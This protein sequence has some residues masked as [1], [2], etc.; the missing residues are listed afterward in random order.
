MSSWSSPDKHRSRQ[1]HP[2]RPRRADDAPRAQC[3]RPRHRIACPNASPPESLRRARLKLNAFY[4]GNQVV[5]ELS[6]DGA[7]IDRERVVDE[8]RRRTTSSPR[9]KQR[10][11][12]KQEALQPDLPRPA[13]APPSAVTEISGRGMG[14]DIVDSV[15]RRLKGSIGIQT[16]RGRG[17]TFQLRVPLTLAIMQAL[18]FRVGG[19]V[20]CRA[21][22]HRWS[23][24]RAP[25]AQQIHTVDHHEVLQLRDQIVTLVRLDRLEGK[26]RPSPHS[27]NGKIFVVVVALAIAALAWS[28]TNWMAKKNWSSRPWKITWSPPNW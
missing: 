14:M 2:R 27:G 20:V 8:S 25:R 21:A 28:S 3:R 11:S 16:E 17:T 23:R 4:Q 19:T 9:R 10:S 24:L 22:R 12:A 18:L 1:E 15:L 6:D 13:S 7:G 5:I 26:K